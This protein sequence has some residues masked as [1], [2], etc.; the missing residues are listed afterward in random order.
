MS[1]A[2]SKV[3]GVMFWL[4]TCEEAGLYNGK[5][6]MTLT[7]SATVENEA[8]FEKIKKKFQDGLHVATI[9][10]FNG[11]M[12]KVLKEDNAD[13]ERRIR[14]LETDLLGAKREAAKATDELNRIKD[15]FG[16]LTKRK[17][18]DGGV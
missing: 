7:I 6:S 13:Y 17:S 11:Q 9:E 18:G 2:D 3:P 5:R 4:D 8:V 14:T 15:S 16:F 10:D 1:T 12:I